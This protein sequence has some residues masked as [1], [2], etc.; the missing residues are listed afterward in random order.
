MRLTAVATI[1]RLVTDNITTAERD[2][3][4]SKPTR[5]TINVMPANKTA[6]PAE[7][8]PA[9]SCWLLNCHQAVRPSW[10][11]PEADIMLA[12]TIAAMM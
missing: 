12:R 8:H 2:G 4:T 6:T 9:P 10:I 5:I 11:N 7:C 1:P 3:Q